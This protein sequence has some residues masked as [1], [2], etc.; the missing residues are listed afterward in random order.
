MITSVGGDFS[1]SRQKAGQDVS[2]KSWEKI[3]GNSQVKLFSTHHLALKGSDGHSAFRGYKY[4]HRKY[5]K[6]SE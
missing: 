5:F 1:E 4:K 2:T 6:Y 3:T